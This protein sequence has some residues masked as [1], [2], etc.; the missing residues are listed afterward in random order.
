MIKLY[1][2]LLFLIPSLFGIAQN[3]SSV[4]SSAFKEYHYFEKTIFKICPAGETV[5]IQLDILGYDE[6]SVGSL[7]DDL[8]T[9]TDKIVSVEI[10]EEK[11]QLMLV[12]N[13]KMVIEELTELFDKYQIHYRL[14]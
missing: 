11:G 13:N 6:N 5:S 3:E 12:Y 14:K 10:N 8:S 7:K 4:S 9:Y 2:S 1:F